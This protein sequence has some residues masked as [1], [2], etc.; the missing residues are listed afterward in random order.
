MIRKRSIG[1]RIGRN[2]RFKSVARVYD[3]TLISI[4]G[5]LNALAAKLKNH[6]LNVCFIDLTDKMGPWL[7]EDKEGPF[8]IY[9]TENT[10][11]YYRISNN[12]N[13]RPVERGFSLWLD[14]GPCELKGPLFEKYVHKFQLSEPVLKFLKDA[15][16]FEALEVHK[17]GSMKNSPYEKVWLAHLATN[18]AS[19]VYYDFPESL[20]KGCPLPL[21]APLFLRQRR[22]DFSMVDLKTFSL[23]MTIEQNSTDSYLIKADETLETQ[24][25]VWGLSSQETSYYSKDMLSYLFSNCSTESE[26]SWVRYRFAFHTNHITSVWPDY[27]VLLRDIYL[28]FTHSQFAIVQKTDRKNTFDIWVRI[29]EHKRFDEEYLKRMCDNLKNEL[30][31]RIENIPISHIDLPLEGKFSYEELGPAPFSCYSKSTLKQLKP[32]KGVFFDSPET[33]GRLDWHMMTLHHKVLFQKLSNI[34]DQK[35]QGSKK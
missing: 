10:L 8:G 13:M 25:I 33:W 20:M 19:N 16:S 12:G 11:E 17:L 29:S 30:L 3:C 24:N 14:D 1:I 18:I 6:G 34:Y 27:F 28:P 26:W 15:L 35:Q 7:P 22:T 2:E 21:Q 31:R 32:Q 9:Q 5:R 23:P 4:Y